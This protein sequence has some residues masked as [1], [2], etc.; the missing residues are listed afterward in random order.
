[1]P[2]SIIKVGDLIRNTIAGSIGIIIKIVPELDMT[3]Y[4][5]IVVVKGNDS[6]YNVFEKTFDFEKRLIKLNE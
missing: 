6:S 5:Y 1:M 3:K 4:H 2:K